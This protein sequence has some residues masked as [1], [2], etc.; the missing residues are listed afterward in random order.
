[1]S[2]SQA[3]VD[4][5]RKN[6]LLSTGPT[7]EEGKNRSRANSLKHGLTGEGIVLPVEDVEE[8]DRLFD[9][10][11]AEMKPGNE[12]ARR[13]VNR[14]ALLTVRL[15]RS[16]EHEAKAIAHKMRKATA[17]FDDARWSEMEKCYSWIAA[18]PETNARR[19]RSSPEGLR[20][21]LM[22]LGDLRDNLDHPDGFRWDWHH[23]EQL[24]HL[25]GLRRV[26]VPVSRF[27][28]LSDAMEGNF[29]HLNK[30]DG[31]DLD[32]ND[33]REWARVALLERIDAEMAR[34]QELLDRFDLEG[35][36]LDREEAAHRVLFDPSPAATLARKYEA[37]TERG[38]FR[39]LKEFRE[40][41]VN[42]PQV[43]LSPDPA[44]VPAEALGSFLPEAPTEP[45]AETDV[46]ATESEAPAGEDGVEPGP[47]KTSRVGNL[48]KMGRLGARLPAD[49]AIRE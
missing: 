22:V 47:E 18:E 23:C 9:T 32:L 20:R 48:H 16:A 14:V 6:A 17:E 13:L 12:L 49:P 5:N 27:R 35:L 8:I 2:T 33:R 44:P 43:D 21:I 26:D 31:S 38:L 39:T 3:R 34:H 4:A 30:A 19:L 7:S 28:A 29:R 11:A 45:I 15:E 42:V 10:L 37:S 41:Q 40:V 36:E 24:H 1:M 46:D 25:L